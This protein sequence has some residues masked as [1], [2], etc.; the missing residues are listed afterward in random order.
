M[1]GECL[2]LAGGARD[3]I[4]TRLVQLA[5]GLL[6]LRTQLSVLL[7]EL[8]LLLLQILVRGLETAKLFV[9]LPNGRGGFR[10]LRRLLPALAPCA[11]QLFT[12]LLELFV[13]RGDLLTGLVEF[14][15][16]VN[17]RPG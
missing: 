1:H 5:A 14:T 17:W 8:A 16:V 11:L 10:G 3:A 6:K 7:L 4:V 2:R 12:E 9:V 15:A 13:L